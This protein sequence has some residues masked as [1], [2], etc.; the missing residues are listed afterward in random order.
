MPRA[1]IVCAS[2]LLLL[3]PS[4]ATASPAK[5]ARRLAAIVRTAALPMSVRDVGIRRSGDRVTVTVSLETGGRSREDRGD[6][7][8][9]FDDLGDAVAAA[10]P[11]R[12]RSAD[13]SFVVDGVAL[14]RWMSDGAEAQ[15]NTMENVGGDGSALPALS[16][17]GRRIALSAGHGW[18]YK[19]A[20]TG[21]T[22]QRSWFYGIVEDF[23]NADLAMLVQSRL[24]ASGALVTP[25]RQMSKTAGTG[26]SGKP[27]WQEASRY[28]LRAIGAPSSIW[29]EAGYSTLSQD[30]RCRPRYANYV[31]AAALVS[32]HNNGGLGTGTEVWFDNANGWQGPSKRLADAIRTSVVSAIRQSKYPTWTDRGT[33]SCNGCKGENRLA[34]RPAVIVE[35]AFMDRK[36]PDNTALQDATFR[37]IVAEAIARGVRNYY[38]AQ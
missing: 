10:L 1:A 9:V 16:V 25:L 27:K 15:L 28:H 5:A 26:I 11:K 18:Y 4:V 8:I 22:L 7:E 34:T 30:I 14:S 24:V 2:L 35:L 20:T 3:L 33:K 13:L 17:T 31:G 37:A 21:W 38:A 36:T 12:F 32:I 23:V 19:N 6:A 29:N